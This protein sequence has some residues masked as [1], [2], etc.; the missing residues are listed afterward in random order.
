MIPLS[1]EM[2]ADVVGGELLDA[3]G[4][5]RMI[6]AVTI[7]SRTVRPGSLFVALP[8]E[9]VHGRAYLDDA[10]ARGAAG[11]LAATPAPDDAP[12]GGIVVDDAADA[13]LGLGTWV[14][15]EVDPVVVGVTGSNGKTTTKD[16]VAAA[17]GAGRPTVATPG[18][19]NNELGVPLTC[20]L[21]QRDSEVLVAEM[22]AR[23]HRHIA[24]LAAVLRPQVGVLTTVAPAHLQMFGTIEAVAAAK[25]ELVE[26]LPADGLAVLNA[27]DPR[28]AA[29]A[30]RAACDVWTYGRATDADWC[31][32]SLAFDDAAR[33]RARVRTPGGTRVEVAAP[34]P[35]EHMASNAVA[36]LA[37]AAHLGVDVD[38]AVGA[39]AV[40]PTSRWRMEVVRAGG[41]TI[42]NDAYNANPASMEAALKTLALTAA[43]GRR[44][45]VLGEMA[46]L[47]PD[48]DAA[49]DR[50]GRLVIRLGV[51]G[52]VVVGAAAKP[53]RDAADQEGFYGQG[54][55]F[56]VP[57]V[58]RAVAVLAEHVAPGDVVLVKA[59]RAAGLERVVDGLVRA[60]GRQP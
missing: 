38:A 8:G 23:G 36:A 27:D 45:A 9:H 24:T 47:G 30:A 60:L 48:S 17:V 56:G 33:A 39:L 54:D 49:H 22:G 16:L 31:I 26:A 15:D 18:S 21:L 51:D 25:A 55:L 58:D 10:S 28:V 20:C 12:P 53:I 4:A 1:L 57:D 43:E 3:D 6:D 19:Y 2:V 32:E 13:L 7:D 46:E 14:R 41:V 37:V 5:E 52:L 29:M 35:G 40:A 34:L 11:W 44:W 50:V 42:L 59:S